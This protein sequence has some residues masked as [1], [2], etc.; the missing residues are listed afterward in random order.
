MPDGFALAA[1]SHAMRTRIGQVIA[2]AADMAQTGQFDIVSRAPDQLAAVNPARATLTVYPWRLLPNTSWASSRQAAY[3]PSGERRASPLLAL[4]ILYVLGAYAQDNANAEA[5][6]G[7][8][9]LGLHETPLLPR[10]MLQ[11]MAAGTFPAGSPLPQALLDLAEQA[12][13]LTV[14]PVG[15][16][17]E[18]FSQVWSLFNSGVRTGMIYRV[19]TLLMESRRHAASAPPVREARSS[20]TLLRRPTIV[21]VLFAAGAAGPFEERA[22]ASPAEVMRIEGAGLRG[23]VT[24]VSIGDV[25]V[26]A[27]VANTRDDRIELSLPSDLRPGLVTLQVR[28]E[29]LK[30]EGELPPAAAGTI[31]GE[32]SNL[33]PL[34]IRPVLDA[35]T[36]FAIGN[37]R[38]GADGAV[39][40]DVTASFDVA[41]GNRQPLD[42]LLNA[43]A[44]G[45]GG[46]FAS[47]AFSA[48]Q[49]APGVEEA[50]VTSR[51][52][53]IAGLPAGN[54]L[55]RVVVDGAESALEADGTGVTGPVLTVP[56]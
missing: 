32:R 9:L 26:P 23:D 21:R 11:A 39:R 20:V 45:P 30:P 5:V 8:A 28:H 24:A 10:P 56:A 54:Y 51:I 7:I 43:L 42:L 4:D 36:P 12:A 33:V 47:F 16:S 41:I 31:P 15:Y 18:E 22:V 55:A 48:P 19:G 44:A 27:D 17:L 37:R 3:S 2:A 38:S 49:P 1:L 29:W 53:T 46:R 40:F 14:E 50:Q 34:A 6:L 25:R 35:V 13:P 52:V